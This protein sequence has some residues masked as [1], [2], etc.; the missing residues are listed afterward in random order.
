MPIG[1]ED[2][3]MICPADWPA[4]AAVAPGDLTRFAP[5]GLAMSPPPVV[6][7]WDNANDAMPRGEFYGAAARSGDPF[8][9]A[10]INEA[11]GGIV[12][13]SGTID[14]ATLRSMAALLHVFSEETRYAVYASESKRPGEDRYLAQIR[15]VR[16]AAMLPL[17]GA[18]PG[19]ATHAQALSI[20]ELLAAFVQ[21]QQQHWN[22]ASSSALEGLLG[23]DGDTA[24]EGLGFGFMVENGSNGVYRL[25]SRP[26]LVTK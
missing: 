5:I 23:G 22:A 11:G 1:I 4:G 25:W 20:G 2:R 13:L 9:D 16:I 10:P 12:Y 15:I 6:M 24:S 26:W 21:A 18:H 17:F 3:V 14:T 8:Q 19:A 7:P